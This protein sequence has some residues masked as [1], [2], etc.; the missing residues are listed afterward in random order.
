MGPLI[1]DPWKSFDCD[2]GDNNGCEVEFDDPE[3]ADGGRDAVYYVRALQTPQD[4]I[5]AGGLRCEFD[6]QG[7]CIK[8]NYCIGANAKPDMDCLS[9]AEPRAWTSPIFV[10]Y[11]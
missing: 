10:E 4:T 8:R 2:I 1:E 6:E 7:Q 9:E 3:F 11:Q 5:N